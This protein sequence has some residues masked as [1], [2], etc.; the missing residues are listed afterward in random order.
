MIVTTI[1]LL[2]LPVKTNSKLWTTAQSQPKG[3]H[4]IRLFGNDTL[5]Y[6]YANIYVGTPPQKQSVIVDT[7]SDYLAFPCSSNFFSLKNL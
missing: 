1:F 3:F 2:S 4:T 5:K 7:G 6:Y